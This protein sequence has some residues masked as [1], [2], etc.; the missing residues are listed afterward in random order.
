M[1]VAMPVPAQA[2]WVKT[3]LFDRGYLSQIRG[4]AIK[5][6]LVIIEACNGITRSK[7]HDQPEPAYEADPTLLSYCDRQ[8]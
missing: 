2:D 4:E 8:S 1:S 5:V 7:R 6:Y 3:L